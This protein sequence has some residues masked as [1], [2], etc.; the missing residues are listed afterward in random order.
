MSPCMVDS[1]RRM[2]S[3]DVQRIVRSLDKWASGELGADLTWHKVA[4]ESGFSRQSLNANPEI[5]AA[6]LVA[7]GSLKTGGLANSR[8]QALKSNEDL[9][10]ENL[11]LKAELEL[12][13]QRENGWLTRW[14]RIAYH[15]RASGH[16]AV[17][18]DRPIPSGQKTPSVAEVKSALKA[19]DQEIP[20]SGRV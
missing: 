6:Y 14:Q 7:K 1:S 15:I 9:A 20:P 8:V 16:Q 11:R 13:K 3:F 17:F 18:I 2:S 5:K 4:E 10:A 12:Y 19:F